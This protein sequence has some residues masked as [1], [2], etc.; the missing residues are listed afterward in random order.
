[1]FNPF[2]K[3]S[4]IWRWK[5]TDKA[6]E[7]VQCELTTNI[8]LLFSSDPR[9]PDVFE[10]ATDSNKLISHNVAQINLY[11]SDFVTN[12]AEIKAFLGMT[13]IMSISKLPSTTGLLTITLV[14]KD[15]ELRDVMTKSRFKEMCNI[16]FSDNDLADSNNKGNKVGPLLDHFNEALQNAMVNSR[17]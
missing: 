3:K 13:S 7:K 1:M 5:S 9:L 12:D 10:K 4:A 15:L 2:Y 11:T 6:S 8:L 17:N 14:T 16:H